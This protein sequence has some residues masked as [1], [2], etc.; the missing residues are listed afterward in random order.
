MTCTFLAWLLDSLDLLRYGSG[1]KKRDTLKLVSRVDYGFD[2][3]SVVSFVIKKFLVYLLIVK[4]CI[5]LVTQ[6]YLVQLH[7]HLLSSGNKFT[8]IL[9]F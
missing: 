5:Y 9:Y 4:Q 7:F 1:S 8:D 2:Q 6:I 3:W